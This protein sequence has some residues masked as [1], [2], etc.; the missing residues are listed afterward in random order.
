MFNA[1]RTHQISS[2][3]CWTPRSGIRLRWSM[4]A[5][6]S[7]LPQGSQA[8]EQSR[9]ALTMFATTPADEALETMR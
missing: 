2:A 8:R 7:A 5:T 9:P 1:R 6:P 3:Y 4:P